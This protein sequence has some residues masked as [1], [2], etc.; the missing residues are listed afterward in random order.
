MYS[1]HHNGSIF[2]EP[3]AFIPERWLPRD[4]MTADEKQQLEN[5]KNFCIPFSIGPRACIGR[6]IV[7]LESLM[8]IATLVHRYD[9]ELPSEDWEMDTLERLNINPAGLWVRVKKRDGIVSGPGGQ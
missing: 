2:P 6:N 8:L 5:L 9:F 7:Y 3:H 4:N 1:L